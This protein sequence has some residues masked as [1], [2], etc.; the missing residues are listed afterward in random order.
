MDGFGSLNAPL[1]GGRAVTKPFT[2]DGDRLSVNFSTSG[3]GRL[4][5]GLQEPDGA[6]I[7]GFTLADCDLQY[8]DE[9][10]R[11]VSWQGRTDVAPLRG[12]PV[13]MGIELKDADLY[14][15]VFAAPGSRSTNGTR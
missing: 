12:R 4:R 6:A 13:R 2:F 5:I 11:V 8:G 15:F 7:P 3:G 10:E 1:T 9:L 14:S